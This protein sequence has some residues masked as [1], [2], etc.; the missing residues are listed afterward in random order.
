MV[1]NVY[2]YYICQLHNCLPMTVLWYAHGQMACT[3][4][5]SGI[6]W[7]RFSLHC[8]QLLSVSIEFSRYCIRLGDLA[9]GSPSTRPSA[10]PSPHRQRQLRPPFIRSIIPSEYGDRFINHDQWAHDCKAALM[11]MPCVA[12][13]VRCKLPA[14]YRPTSTPNSWMLLKLT[15]NRHCLNGSQRG[16]HNGNQPMI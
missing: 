9:P 10:P 6:Y 2:K 8:S 15:R 5:I 14:K 12:E 7:S 16:S 1:L 4:K 11:A 3:S 13:M